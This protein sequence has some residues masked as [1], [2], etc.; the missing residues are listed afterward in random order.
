MVRL[1][2]LHPEEGERMEQIA[3][4]LPRV[5][6]GEW[7]TPKRVADS[8]IALI[9][10]SGIH[11]RSDPP[12]RPG[13]SEY[14]LLPDDLDPAELVMTHVSA[15]FDRTAFQQDPNV[16]LPLERLHELVE[17]GEV[18]SA[19]RWHYA[20]MGAVPNVALLEAVGMEV[21][22]LLARDGVDAAVLLPV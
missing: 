13:I 7:I 9:T 5:Q 8:R 4:Q 15:N 21:G 17:A 14:R 18:G 2:D 19:S 10:T 12:F 6:A 22:E 1:S 20:F 16:M 3:A 11:R